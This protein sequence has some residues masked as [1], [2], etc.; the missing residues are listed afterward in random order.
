M[1]GCGTGC[2]APM[3]ALRDESCD[4]LR[5]V[6]LARDTRLL[7]VSGP[8]RE[9]EVSYDQLV[10]SV[11][12]VPATFGVKGVSEHCVFMKARPVLPGHVRI[13]YQE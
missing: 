12:E 13:P 8:D 6:C 4:P 7:T 10:V 5:L 11:G 2:G 1:R 9:F 3:A